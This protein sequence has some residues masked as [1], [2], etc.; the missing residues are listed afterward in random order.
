MKRAS[1]FTTTVLLCA[2]CLASCGGQKTKKTT[3]A[4][5]AAATKTYQ[6]PSLPAM[7]TDRQEQA[8]WAATH[9]WDN[10]DFADTLSVEKWSEYAEQAFVD[11]DYQLLANI[12]H[13][14]GAGSIDGLFKKAAANKAVFGKFL[15]IAEKYLFDPNS[16][17]RNEEYYIA[18]LN[19]VLANPTLD[20][21]ERIRP[22]EQ[23]RLAMKNRV[24]DTAADFRY[25][26]ASG[27]TGMM[28][29]LRARY[30]LLFFNNPGCPACR[31]TMGQITGSPFL[32]R[33]IDEGTLAVL[34]VYPDDDIVAWRDYASNI[35]AAWINSHD[36]TQTIK[37][38][39]VYD[40]KAIPTL[41]LLDRDKRVM[42][43]DVMSIPL[44][45]ETINSNMQ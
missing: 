39:E 20:E 24:G 30:T 36:A 43:K 18:V 16:P 22:A 10:F 14:M 27:A 33:L 42:L 40:L 44:I 9:Y 38:E 13:E 5:T 11:Y 19:A 45:E 34:A 23:L 31:E 25:T 26:L 32:S 3:A 29:G 2:S 6:M 17:F 1:L 8:Q 7:I 4:D 15:E 28:R 35:P 12:P 21:W 37:G 41:Y